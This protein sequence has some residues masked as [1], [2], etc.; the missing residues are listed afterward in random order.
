M[1]EEEERGG[2]GGRGRK[3]GGG[4]EGEEGEEKGKEARC[5][6]R[7]NFSQF[8]SDAICLSSEGRVIVEVRGGFSVEHFADFLLIIL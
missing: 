7:D 4:K 2:R 1:E 5:E 8:L 6:G 3:G